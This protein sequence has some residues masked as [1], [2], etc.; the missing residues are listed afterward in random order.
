[1]V[2]YIYSFGKGEED[3]DGAALNPL[4]KL[5]W[6]DTQSSP[7]PLP[8]AGAVWATLAAQ[9]ISVSTENPLPLQPLPCI[10]PPIP[11]SPGNLPQMVWGVTSSSSVSKL[12][13]PDTLYTVTI[14][15][16]PSPGRKTEWPGL[17]ARNN[18][19][20]EPEHSSLPCSGKAGGEERS[21]MQT[22]CVFPSQHSLQTAVFI[23][24]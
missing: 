10:S 22:V 3:Y 16:H 21:L 7:L 9:G 12:L 17:A 13:W 6:R 23:Q 14:S 19:S 1:M 5:T 8:E 20:V 11:T 15:E 24:S 4:Q 18:G 2:T